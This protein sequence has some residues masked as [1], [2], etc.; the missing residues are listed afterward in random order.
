MA[1]KEHKH[2]V[3]WKLFFVGLES[4]GTRCYGFDLSNEIIMIS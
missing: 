3:R 2:A 1:Q 4:A